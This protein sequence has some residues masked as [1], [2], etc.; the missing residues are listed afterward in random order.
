MAVADSDVERALTGLV[1][2]AAS[3]LLRCPQASFKEMAASIALDTAIPRDH[4]TAAAWRH[5]NWRTG[6]PRFR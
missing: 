1:D 5:L 4:L 3:R 6:R 2:W